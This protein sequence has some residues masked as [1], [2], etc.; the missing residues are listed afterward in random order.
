MSFMIISIVIFVLL[1]L[2]NAL[3]LGG[4]NLNN[5]CFDDNFL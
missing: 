2:K 4:K 3:I 1:P 5:I